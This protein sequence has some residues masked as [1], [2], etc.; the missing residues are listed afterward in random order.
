[1]EYIQLVLVLPEHSDE[2]LEDLIKRNAE[3]IALSLLAASQMESAEAFIQRVTTVCAVHPGTTVGANLTCD[4]CLLDELS[5]LS[6]RADEQEREGSVTIATEERIW[7]VEQAL[8]DNRIATANLVRQQEAETRERWAREGVPM[9][10]QRRNQNGLP[11]KD[12]TH[13]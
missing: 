11:V 8:E 1:V 7:A 13:E 6:V 4:M 10:V 3:S 9:W 5:D 2:D 12:F